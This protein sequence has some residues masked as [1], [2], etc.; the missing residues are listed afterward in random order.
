MDQRMYFYFLHH[1][2]CILVR[3]LLFL[4]GGSIR[5]QRFRYSQ[6]E[7]VVWGKILTTLLSVSYVR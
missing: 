3:E 1:A 6:K 7:T 5:M 2:N 4:R